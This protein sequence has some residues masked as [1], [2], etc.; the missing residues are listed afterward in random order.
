MHL[1][2]R[3]PVRTH[4]HW[5]VVATAHPAKFDV[6]LEPL[7]GYA[8]PVPPVLDAMLQRPAQATPMAADERALERWLREP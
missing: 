6:V 7:L 2:E 8:V 4:G 1:L 5:V 3:E